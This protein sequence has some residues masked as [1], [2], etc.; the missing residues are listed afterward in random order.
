MADK[1]PKKFGLLKDELDFIF[2]HFGTTFNSIGK[3]FLVKLAKDK[4]I[5]RL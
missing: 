4:K 5:D 2:K 3:D 1:K